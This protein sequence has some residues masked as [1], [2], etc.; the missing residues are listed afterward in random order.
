VAEPIVDAACRV[1]LLA[2][3]RPVGLQ[4]PIDEGLNRIQLRLRAWLVHPRWRHRIG[5]RLPHDATMDPQ[6]PGHALN[7]P[8]AELILPPNLRE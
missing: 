6:L 2:G 3:R 4:N 1:P 7:R 8:D 5:Q